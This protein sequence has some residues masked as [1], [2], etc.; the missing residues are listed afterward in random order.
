[1]TRK[2][3]WMKRIVKSQISFF[4]PKEEEGQEQTKWTSVTEKNGLQYKTPEQRIVENV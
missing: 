4:Y 2:N 1:M 3:D